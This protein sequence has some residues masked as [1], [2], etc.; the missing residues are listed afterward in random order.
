MDK[1]IAFIW[2]QFHN[3]DAMGSICILYYKILHL[4]FH[5]W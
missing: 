3:G 5:L 2:G 1:A 4:F